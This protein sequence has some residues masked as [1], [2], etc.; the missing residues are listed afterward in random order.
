MKTAIILHGAPSKEEYYDAN[1]PSASNHH[2]IPWL[3]KQLLVRNIVAHTPEV[4]YSFDPQYDVWVREFERYEI[5]EETMLVGHSCGG[6]FLTR[7]LSEN[8]DRKVNRVILVAPWLDPTRY[9][10]SAF[11]NFEIDPNLAERT[12]GF[13]I[14]NSTNDAGDIQDSAFHIRDTVKNCY[15][16]DFENAGHFCLENLGTEAFPELLDMLICPD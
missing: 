14:F 2:W 15:F 5:N 3:Q 1:C 11:F 9:R 7:W 4:P 10:T 13:A 16:R 6:G 8:K 12:N